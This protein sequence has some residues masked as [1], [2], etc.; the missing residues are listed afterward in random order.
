VIG[1]VELAMV[2]IE[3]GELAS[4]KR[5]IEEA[6]P[7]ARDT[8][9]RP[10][11]AMAFFL[12]GEIALAEDDLPA[13]RKHHEAALQIRKE[14]RE[15]RTI[16]ESRVALANIALEE[17]HALDAEA[18]INDL[19]KDLS[20]GGPAPAQT[21]ADLLLVQA[22]LDQ[23]KISAA[24]VAMM[25]AQ[26]MAV[27]AQRQDE[28]AM[29]IITDA[30]LYSARKQPEVALQK[31]NSLLPGLNQNGAIQLQLETRLAQCEA[32][33]RSSPPSGAQECAVSLAKDSESRGFKRI[34]RKA[35]VLLRDR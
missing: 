12:L 9:L 5:T 1:R 7:L 23:N 17:G 26:K 20:G 6:F 19:Q 34:A 21:M 14:L 33:F 8:K 35:R 13:A 22:L 10:G 18:A 11:E 28:R 29:N 31:L 4:A 15:D 27:A 3:M 24:A 32:R 2:L 25:S 16:L 30:R